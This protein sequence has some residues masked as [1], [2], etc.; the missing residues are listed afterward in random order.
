MIQFNQKDENILEIE[1]LLKIG[2]FKTVNHYRVYGLKMEDNPPVL[3]EYEPK[4][5][6]A[7]KL[8]TLSAFFNGNGINFQFQ[9]VEPNKGKIYIG[10][11]KDLRQELALCAAIVNTIVYFLEGKMKI[12]DTDKIAKVPSFEV[13]LI[14]KKP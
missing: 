6:D 8:K 5:I 12:S 9:V 11:R 7:A 4:Q 2:D 3:L 10:L 13:K 1:K 14:V